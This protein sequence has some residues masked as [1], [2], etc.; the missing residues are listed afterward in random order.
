[1]DP[2]GGSGSSNLTEPVFT[3]R[4]VWLGIGKMEYHVLDERGE[5]AGHRSLCP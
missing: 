2:S 3:V 5:P 1:M 4:L